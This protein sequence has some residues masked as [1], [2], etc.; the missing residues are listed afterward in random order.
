M[1]PAPSQ[2]NSIL[3][4]CFAGIFATAASTTV[5]WSAAVLLPAF[6]GR[7]IT[8]SDS[9]VLSHQAVSG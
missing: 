9:S 5:M 1:D 4:R 2:V 6:P 8:A 7:S 3:R